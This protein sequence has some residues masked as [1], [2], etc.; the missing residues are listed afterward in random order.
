MTNKYVSLAY[1]LY[2][3]D[4]GVID[5]VEEATDDKPF[6]FISGFRTTLDKFERAVVNLSADETFEFTIPCS[7]AYG[8]F[9]DD[10]VLDLDKSLFYQNGVFDEE[11]VYVG[12]VVPL[13]STEGSKFMGKVLNITDTQVKVDL[14]HPLAGKDLKFMGHVI[15]NR[16]PTDEEIDALMRQLYGGG[17]CGC[18]GGCGSGCG[19]QGGCGSSSEG[20]SCGCG[21][22]CSCGSG[23][24]DDTTGGGC[25]CGCSSGGCGCGDVS[26]PVEQ[27]CGC[28]CSSGGCGCGC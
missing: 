25:G 24:A 11:S 20:S 22:G 17:S 3:E 4:N 13:M 28:G 15:E 14:N 21:G 16:E 26:E 10:R 8:E 18:G 7:D 9:D 2:T 27:G 5:L 12:A 23:D 1:K 6:I 19:S